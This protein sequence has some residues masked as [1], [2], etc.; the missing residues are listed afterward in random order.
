MNDATRDCIPALRSRY[1]GD[2]T[3]TTAVLLIALALL[4]PGP[5]CRIA[6]S[7]HI[8]ASESAR[9]DHLFAAL[10]QGIQP[11]A[12]VLVIRDGRIVHEAAYGY[13]DIEKQIP[14]TVDSTFRLDSVSKQFT[15]MAVM[16]LAEDGKL[17]Y[18]DPVS[19]YVPELVTYPGVTVRHLLTHTGG[20]PDYY[21][22]IDTTHGW[23]S[24]AD[25]AKL[26]GQLAKPVFAPGTRHEYSNAGYDM[27]A[28]VVEGASGQ[29]FADFVRN[30]IFKSVGMQHSL[31]HDHTRPP[32]E[33]RVLGYDKTDNGFALNDEHPLNGI[34][35]SGGVFTTLG[36]M[37]LWDQALYGDRLVSR[38][39]IQQAFTPYVLPDG[40]STGYGF[41]WRIDEYRGIRR[42]HHGGSWVGFRSHISRY[43]DIGLT[44]VILSNRGDFEPPGYMDRITD[45]YLRP[46][47]RALPPAAEAPQ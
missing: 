12:G 9:V 38:A 10:K 26:L 36:D 16:L 29:R 14:L 13:A 22:V 15:A 33:R 24:N 2:G 19:R 5:F 21:D 40:E 28:Q 42:V 47:D 32:V 23:P 18:D 25:A 35:G 7:A 17:A 45:I 30:R 11:G 37:Y 34:V 27:L 1:R 20:L 41:A 6:R 44:I 8:D 43:P 3:R 4:L 46:A 31:V 39:T